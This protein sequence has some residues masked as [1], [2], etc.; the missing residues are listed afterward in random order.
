MKSRSWVGTGNKC[1][2]VKPINRIPTSWWL[3]IESQHEL[4]MTINRIPTWACDDYKNFQ[5][6][7]LTVSIKTGIHKLKIVTC[8]TSTGYL[9]LATGFLILY[10]FNDDFVVCNASVS[11]ASHW[12]TLSH[13]VVSSTPRLSE[14]R[15]HNVSGDRYWL[16]G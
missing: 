7:D 14:I 12:Q 3:L 6:Y 16:H 5:I 13:N 4:V 15:T 2:S 11:I 8:F 1:G 9:S 10:L